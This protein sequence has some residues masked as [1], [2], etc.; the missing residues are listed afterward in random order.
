MNAETTR[1]FLYTLVIIWLILG[2]ILAKW[3]MIKIDDIYRENHLK[4][5][6][7]FQNDFWCTTMLFFWFILLPY[8]LITGFKRW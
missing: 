5:L 2:A 6:P 7:Q 8:E 3:Y 4:P 1:I